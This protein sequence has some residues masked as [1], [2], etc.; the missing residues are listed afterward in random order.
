MSY[1]PLIDPL[2]AI[3]AFWVFSYH[4]HFSQQMSQTLP[5]VAWISHLGWLGVPMF[6]VISGFC[7]TAAARR[8]LQQPK[9]FSHFIWRR[10]TRIYPPFW[11]S[12]AITVAIPF[13][14]EGL[15]S[16]KT[17]VY[18][19]VDADHTVSHQFVNYNFIDWFSVATL[20][21]AFRNA[22]IADMPLS[23]NKFVT[24]N[25]VYWTL[26]I[27]VQFYL[28]VAGCMLLKRNFYAGMLA[29]TIISLLATRF[30]PDIRLLGL[31]FPYWPSFAFGAL[32]FALMELKLP[33]SRWPNTLPAKALSL[34]FGGSLIG[35]LFVISNELEFVFTLLF[36]GFLYFSQS[37][38]QSLDALKNNPNS[39][40]H[41][42]LFAI[43]CF[44]GTASYSIYL[45][46]GRLQHLVMVGTRQLF[47]PDTIIFDLATL[48]LTTLLCLGFF[49]L[50][51][52][53]FLRPISLTRRNL[54]Q[55]IT[56]HR[57]S[58]TPDTA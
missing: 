18:S 30:I 38:D 41:R 52:K 36:A 4:Y 20:L 23:T 7:I 2:R 29:V 56:P 32:V 46:H 44:L 25:A 22:P 33:P 31:C 6:F 48:A 15:S 14:I 53:P 47:P 5:F 9:A 17:G 43:I 28:L 1:L 11:C 51:E 45:L 34:I 16:L 19:G 12:I 42:P 26:A 21:Q 8:S 50:C 37:W 49:W 35:L 40:L 10:F 55:E 58:L 39:Y 24:I 3:A 54:K 27:E 13:L 57:A